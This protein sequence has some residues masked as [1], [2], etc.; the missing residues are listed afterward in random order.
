VLDGVFWI[1]RTGA[2]WRD[3][4]EVFGNWNSIWRQFRRWCGSGVWDVRRGWPI[5][6]VDWTRECRFTNAVLMTG[7]GS[8]GLTCGTVSAGTGP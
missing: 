7:P 8:R 3:L 6:A 5:A 2:P 4:P 1:T